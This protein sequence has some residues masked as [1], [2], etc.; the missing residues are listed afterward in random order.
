[1]KVLIR[2][3]LISVFEGVE[4]SPGGD[5]Q[6]FAIGIFAA[7]VSA[8]IVV[9]Q[10]YRQRYGILNSLA[11]SGP[12]REAMQYDQMLFIGLAMAL[13]TLVTLLLWDSLFPNRRDC[14]A[15]AGLPI[16]PAEIFTAKFTSVAILFGAYVLSLNLPWALLFSAASMGRL[17]ETPTGVL[18]VL[19]NF[20]AIAAA[21]CFAFL[22]LL[23]VQGVLLNILPVRLFNRLGVW[24]QGT[25][26]I[27]TLGAIPIVDRQPGAAGSAAW[28]PVTWFFDLRTAIVTASLRPARAALMALFVSAAIG[29]VTYLAAYRRHRR[30]LLESPASGRAFSLHLLERWI[31][32]SSELAAFA[33]IGKTLVR[34]KTHRLLLL[35]Y[36]GLALGWVVKG[37]LDMPPPSLRDQGMYGMLV[38]VSPLAVAILVVVALRHLF[39]LPV[40]P[41]ANWIFQIEDRNGARHWLTAVERFV[42]TFGIAPV[43]LASLPATIAILGLN[44]ALAVTGLL[45]L[46]AL[47][48]FEVLF[49]RWR[50]LPFTCTYMPPTRPIAVTLARYALASPGLGLLGGFFLYSSQEPAAFIAALTL[51]LG[52]YCRLRRSRVGQVPSPAI[53]FTESPP[54]EIE[55]LHLIAPEGQIATTTQTQPAPELFAQSSRGILP[56]A[57]SDE[58]EA[59][60]HNF[61]TGFGDDIRHGLRLVRRNPVLSAAV[62]VTLA[63]AIGVN[64]SVF[65]VVQGLMFRPHISKDPASF[66]EVF[67]EAWSTRLPREASYSEYIA[68]REARSLRQ[69]AAWSPFPALFGDDQS[70]TFGMVVSCNFFEV[71]GVS[72]P[73]LGRLLTASDCAP[74]STSTVA[75]ISAPTW[76]SRFASDPAIIGRSV[77]LN[78]RPVTVVG[79][80][81]EG[82]TGWSMGRSIAVWLPYTTQ[83]LF[84]P[85]R[86]LFH[87]DQ[88][89]WLALAGRIAPG[90]NVAAVHAELT[91]LIRQQD[92]RIPGRVSYIETTDGSVIQ[93]L[94]LSQSGR[95]LM[96]SAFFFGAFNLVLLIAC[97]NVSTLLLSRAAARRREIAVRLALGAPRIRLARMLITES[98][99]LAALAG[100]ASV[101]IVWRLPQPLAHYLTPKSVTWPLPPDWRTFAY[102]AAVAFVTGILAGLAPAAETFNSSL[103]NSL[104]GFALGDA[105]GPK[106]SLGILVAGQ[107][108]MSMVLLVAAGLLG[109]AENRN[110]HANPGYNPRSVVVS[111]LRFPETSTPEASGIRLNAI[112]SRMSAIPGVRSVAFSEDIPLFRP[113]TAELRPPARPDAIQ[114]VD[115]FPV[116]PHFLETLSVPLVRGRDFQPSDGAAVIV[117]ESLGYAFWR[118]SDPLGRTL[119]LPNHVEA[120]VVGIARDTE[121]LRFGGSDNP[122]LYKLR[123]AGVRNV[124]SVRFD[125]GAARGARAVSAAMREIEPDL[126]ILP[127]LMQTWISEVTEDI[128]N[129]VS[130]ILILGALGALLSTTGIYGAV[131]FVVSQS[132]RELGIR[133]TL[134]ATRFDIVRA[135]IAAGGRPVLHGLIAGLWLSI[136]TAAAL[137][138][139]LVESPIRIDSRD[140]LLYLGALVLLTT[141]ALAAMAGPARRGASVD[142]ADALRCE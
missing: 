83:P 106:R 114:P 109:Q 18:I 119:E 16:S 36:G 110:L 92:R 13:T 104:K 142:P 57:V 132:T 103:A 67:P 87:D 108:A 53:I 20:A 72:R 43:F 100:A 3:F 41:G 133:V 42:L 98:L 50:K 81:P 1:V 64:A 86:D 63:L 45:A 10:T 70:N 96:L 29:A 75:V 95:L 71:E 79:V 68:L 117:S 22:A 74:S 122:A 94:E 31:T 4:I 137:R 134:G 15:L 66:I 9:I 88:F 82:T 61:W 7:L 80:A 99:L 35:S 113:D 139:T 12:Y 128:W 37:A 90:Y 138:R 118:R 2:H 44:R 89:L 85:T 124:M 84:D 14:L 107:V 19:G 123:T 101:Y 47:L 93:W 24:I 97:A 25:L 38:T 30:M 141:A 58:M 11:S 51:Q 73:R 26:F 60:R 115:I 102:I 55:S 6:K 121:P 105:T 76:R 56:P 126:L 131:S 140:P 21:C 8:G 28:W 34:S 49:R 27:A 136:A 23:A 54:P 78:N 116:S 40:S 46:T 120:T 125:S 33:F 130:L 91:T 62:V 65:T 69:L 17:Q 112:A 39:S 32:H 111:P 135:V 5:W 129:F 59:V 127:R 52:L 77:R 48:W